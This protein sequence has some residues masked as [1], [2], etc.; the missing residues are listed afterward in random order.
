VRKVTRALEEAKKRMAKA[1]KA[2][3]AAEVAAA[4]ARG[5]YEVRGWWGWWMGG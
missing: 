5:K 2:Q 4:E 3:H 1:Q